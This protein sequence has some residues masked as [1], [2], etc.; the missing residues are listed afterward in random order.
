MAYSTIR[1]PPDA[2]EQLRRLV[3]QLSAEADQDVTQGEA[4][5]AA[6]AYA[7][8]HLGDVAAR[9]P[10]ESA[11]DSHPGTADSAPGRPHGARDESEK[12]R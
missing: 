4:L 7:L 11:L 5:G 1:V 8:D 10:R 12:Q 3:R 2:I 6:V 9:L